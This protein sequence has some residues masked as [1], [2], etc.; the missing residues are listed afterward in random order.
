MKKFLVLYMTP[1]AV[2]D[3]WM[4]TPAERRKGEEEKMMKEWQQWMSENGKHLADPG[5]GVGKVRRVTAQGASDTRNDIMLYAIVNAES[6][7][8]AA[9]LFTRHPHL[10]IPQSSIDIMELKSQ[11]M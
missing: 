7:D 8:A 4:K 3:D 1:V 6:T 10:Q 5:A 2:L 9:K 11:A